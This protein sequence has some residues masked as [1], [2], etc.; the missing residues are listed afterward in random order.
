MIPQIAIASWLFAVIVT[1]S[2][3]AWKPKWLTLSPP[4]VRRLSI[5]TIAGAVGEGVTLWLGGFW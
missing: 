3:V 4:M 5:Y 2:W 1:F